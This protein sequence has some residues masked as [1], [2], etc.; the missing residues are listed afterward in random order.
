MTYTELL[1][2]GPNSP[3]L[4]VD[5]LYGLLVQHGK[6]YAGVQVQGEDML[7]WIAID[8][9]VDAGYGALVQME[10]D[11]RGTR[12]TQAPRYDVMI[13]CPVT[14]E[15]VYTG[16]TMHIQSWN[17]IDYAGNSVR[18][19]HCGE[20]HV[21]SKRDAELVERQKGWR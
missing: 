9:L 15:H 20:L 6:E 4:L 18:C 8:L 13:R 19:T 14:G 12:D 16:M 10:P 21:W 17:T 3:V 1:K 7:R 11:M 5:G 2:I